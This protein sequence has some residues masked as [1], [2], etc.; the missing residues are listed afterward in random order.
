MSTDGPAGTGASAAVPDDPEQLRQEIERTREQL[1]ETVEAL[2]YKTDVKAR[3]RERA[4][5]LSQR[6]KGTTAQ[7]KEQAAARTIQARAQATARAGQARSQLAGK[8]ADA[9]NAAVATG[10]PA[11]DQLQA[12]AT[13]VGGAVRD[14]TPEP[15]QRAARQVAQRTS[16][17]AGQRRG[18]AAAGRRRGR[19]RGRHRDP[20]EETEVIILKILYKPFG[21][22][23]SVLGGMLA[24][25]IFKRVW[26]L[27]AHEDEAPEATDAQRGWGEVLIAATLQGAIFALVK[28]ATDRGAATVT[29]RLLGFWPGKEADADGMTV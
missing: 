7:V 12:R 24:G 22:V 28:A 26:K 4:E 15:V 29:R 19:R 25:A 10:G 1:G 20:A 23:V 17:V 18:L 13:A 8:T 27:A 11:R 21:I 2:V 14:K 5:Q 6:V 16:A 3:A 9:R